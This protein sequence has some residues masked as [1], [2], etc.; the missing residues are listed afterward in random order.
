MHSSSF[1]DS[2]K[3]D[4]RS[5]QGKLLRSGRLVSLRGHWTGLVL[6]RRH[7]GYRR[8]HGGGRGRWG[9]RGTFRRY[10]LRRRL[11]HP[12][13]ASS[14]SLLVE[15]VKLGLRYV[16]IAVHIEFREG[17]RTEVASGTTGPVETFRSRTEVAARVKFTTFGTTGRTKTFGAA[18]E[19]TARRRRT[20]PIT[21]A[22]GTTRRAVTFG[23]AFEITSGR[24][25]RALTITTA[26]GAALG[27]VA[28]GAA[29]EIAA[30]MV[31]MAATAFPTSGRAI[32]LGATFEIT[33]GRRRRTLS[34]ATAFAVA[35]GVT[36][37]SRARPTILG[38]GELGVAVA[39]PTRTAFGSLDFRAER[40]R[41]IGVGGR[42]L[43]TDHATQT[44]QAQ[45]AK[46]TGKKHR[47]P[48][49]ARCKNLFAVH[50]DILLAVWR[51]ALGVQ[52]FDSSGACRVRAS[53]PSFV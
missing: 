20:L 24:R 8:C 44:N 3:Q 37:A 23:T 15:G 43:G 17:G 10:R 38:P 53:H 27:S 11:G 13:R 30:W 12:G 14:E 33:S 34:V 41:T 51:A 6:L 21:T 1:L 25:R 42:F 32:A 45:R 29:F 22:F 16:S 9:H 28:L 47:R 49:A 5:S 50:L 39:F 18:F 52:G 19:I 4:N 48:G 40:G 26:F 35:P 7:R 31:A 46:A 2:P 36:L